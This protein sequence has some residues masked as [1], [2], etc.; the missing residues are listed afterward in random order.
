MK[1]RRNAAARKHLSLF[2]R[3]APASTVLIL[4]F[5]TSVL[6]WLAA[7]LRDR[8]GSLLPPVIA[9]IAF[10]FGGAI[11]G[12]I[13]VIAYRVTTGTLPPFLR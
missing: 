6:G 4:V 10:N 1:L 3:G 8:T 11:G 7:L 12:A 13:Y 9:H 2:L 5:W